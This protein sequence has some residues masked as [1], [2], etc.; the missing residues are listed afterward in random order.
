MLK[1]ILC[2]T[3]L[4]LLTSYITYSQSDIGPDTKFG[5][6]GK[7]NMTPEEKAA[8]KNIQQKGRKIPQYLFDQLTRAQEDGNIEEENRI[9]NILMTRYYDKECI[10]DSEPVVF[11]HNKRDVQI[12][13]SNYNPDW[14]TNDVLIY[15]GTNF[16][17]P[18]TP[19]TFDIKMGPDG[20]IYVTL[21]KKLPQYSSG[22]L[23]MYY[24]TNEGLTWNFQ[25]AYALGGYRFTGISM[26]VE[27][28]HPTI[29]DSIRVI[30]FLTGATNLNND[31]AKLF[32]FSDN[33]NDAS[34]GIFKTIALPNSG[35]EF[36]FPTAFSNCEFDPLNNDIGCIV[37]EYNNEG[38]NLIA[39]RYLYMSNWSWN[40]TSSSFITGYNDFYP[41]AAYKD[42]LGTDSL[43]IAVERRMGVSGN[44][45]RI[46]KTTFVP[47]PGFSTTYLTSEYNY[48]KPVLNIVQKKWDCNKMII[49]CTRN[50]TAKY[51]YSTNGGALWNINL[52]LDNRP[53]PSNTT[54]Y[55]GVSTD[56]NTSGYNYCVG[57][58]ANQDSINVRKGTL[59]NLGATLYKRNSYIAT[60]NAFP[61]CLL[62]RSGS[63]Y[64]SAF[65]Y[66][67]DGPDSISRKLYFDGEHIPHSITYTYIPAYLYY[68]YHSI[69]L[70][71]TG[72]YANPRVGSLWAKIY[73]LSIVSNG[74]FDNALQGNGGSSSTNYLNTGWATNIG[75][76]SWTISMWLNNLPS[77]TSQNYLFGDHTAGS[78]RCFYSGSAGVHGVTLSLSGVRGNDITVPG[79]GPGP[80]VLTFVYD[81]AASIVHAYKNG[82]LSN[83][84]PQTSPLNI[85]GSGPFKVGGYGNLASM[86]AGSLLDEFRFYNEALNSTDIARTWNQTLPLIT[87]VEPGLNNTPEK[88]T[89]SQNYPNPFNPTTTIEYKTP[90]K[91]LVI[92][93]VYDILGKEIAT[94]VNEVKRAGSYT[95]EFSGSNLPSGTYFYRL[96]A[97]DDL[98]VKKMLLIK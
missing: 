95:V 42:V 91:G 83:S 60:E 26:L 74:Q 8:P 51:H 55:T 93:K 54:L 94:L 79:V 25:Y 87:N 81:S 34:L 86:P 56:T 38:T 53:N 30:V 21:C 28:T 57:I 44:Q 3:I 96:E 16:N 63:N 72:N 27:R 48:E 88:Y 77:T 31:N 80:T 78:F 5:I 68:K 97:G 39:L 70:D 12:N 18:I 45:I 64:C 65:S 52:G 14:N 23:R 59:G 82:V 98:D 75:T 29:D 41:S 46:I 69:G 37:G 9:M 24:S 22:E 7:Y 50:N 71:S 58:F 89:L 62:Y 6:T 73:G 67:G 43:F 76:S 2:S 11:E 1:I 90:T 4:L 13:Q 35:N 36:N 92:L 47:S 61:V 32:V 33:P 20:N 15:D 66:W 84:Q 49:T 10:S 19:R 85:N 17:K 40:F